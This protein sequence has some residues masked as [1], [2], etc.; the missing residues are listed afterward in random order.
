MSNKAFWPGSRSGKIPKKT[1][2][3]T[4]IFRA[5]KVKKA[6]HT[7]LQRSMFQKFA[8]NGVCCDLMHGT[9][10][11]DFVLNSVLVVDEF[12][13]SFLAGW[14]LSSHEDFTTMCRFY[15]ELR[16]NCGE[17]HSE[18]F[19]SDMALQFYNAWV[20]VMGEQRPA[21]LLCMWHVDKAC[22]EELCKKI[23]DLEIAA[24]TYKTLRTVLEQ[25]N[26]TLFQDCLDGLVRKL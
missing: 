19:M 5:K 12:G 18:F 11:Y 24:D 14:Y 16:N 20:G 10:A 15:R 3:S 7:P 1:Q 4:S 25:T 13:A 6:M 17:V 22:K 26:E 9:N 23:G 21:K 8:H 2:C